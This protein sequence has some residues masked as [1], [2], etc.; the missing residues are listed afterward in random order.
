MD[1]LSATTRSQSDFLLDSGNLISG[2]TYDTLLNFSLEYCYIWKSNWGLIK[3]LYLWLRYGIFLD[4]SLDVLSMN[5]RMNLDPSTC[6]TLDKF[7]TIYSGFGIGIGI[8]EGRMSEKSYLSD[9]YIPLD[10]E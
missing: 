3:C 7:I 10:G 1:P 4:I 9:Q 6:I 5:A 8:M 2:Q